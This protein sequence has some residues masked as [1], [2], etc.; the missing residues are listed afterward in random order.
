MYYPT[1]YSDDS[2]KYVSREAY[3]EHKYAPGNGGSGGRGGYSRE[4]IITFRGNGH[5]IRSLVVSECTGSKFNGTTGGTDGNSSRSSR[6]G[7]GGDGQHCNYNRY[8]PSGNNMYGENNSTGGNGSRPTGGTGGMGA[9]YKVKEL[10]NNGKEY[11][12]YHHSSTWVP[13]IS[14]YGRSC[15]ISMWL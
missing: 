14:G 8:T 3:T 13:P 6:G 10:I 5:N 15:R 4:H 2:H 9:S 12:V 1:T 7:A 11:N